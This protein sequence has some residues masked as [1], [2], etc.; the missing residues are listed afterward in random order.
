MSGTEAAEGAPATRRTSSRLT[1]R[2]AWVRNLTRPVRVF[3]ATEVGS[4]VILLA[5]ALA[6]LLWA[7]SPWGDSYEG[8]WS[9]ELSIHLGGTVLEHDLRG[10]VNDGLM[11]FFFFV[12]GLEIRRELDMGDLRERRRVA[13]PV[14]A[15]VGGMAIPALIYASFNA[16]TDA[17][18]G[19]GI[20]MATDTAFALGVLALVGRRWPL[21]LR[22]FVLTLVVVDDV[23]ALTVIALAYTDDLAFTPLL[24]AVG[25]FAVVVALRAAGVRHGAPYFLLGVALWLAL[26]QAGVHPTIAGVSMGLLATAYPPTRSDLQRAASLWRTFREQPTSQYARSASRGV[27]LAISPNERMQQIY[28]PWTS[29]LIVPLFALANAGVALDGELLERA[30][31]S[32]ITLGIVAGLVVGKL[33]GIS[34]AS[35]LA[36]RRWL[37]GFPITIAWPPLI[38]AAIVA[39]IGFT[40]SLFIAELSFEGERLA[41]AKVG[42]LAASAIA[43]GLGWAAFRLMDR[44]PARLR[45]GGR[46]QPAEPLVDLT[47]PVDPERDHIRGPADAPVTLVEYADFECPYCGQAEPVIRELLAEF[48]RDLRYVFR[49]L[50]LEDVH[51]H[52][53]LAAEAAEAAGAQGKF[54][55]MHDLLFQHQDALNK[56]DLIQYAEQLGLDME[57]FEAKLRKRKFA[58][59]VAHD[60]ES[61]DLSGVTGTPTFFANGRRHHGAFNLA[62]LTAL[63]RSALSHADGSSS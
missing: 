43:A 40:V 23:G 52:A 11:A 34:G 58:P 3:V 56:W 36:T 61:A 39:G 24:L 13:L 62:E 6:A 4:A 33:V 32:P 5:A 31:T 50:P 47:D 55:E 9:T 42:I 15:A 29:F 22:V 17:V 19:W 1:G 59:R 54:W 60:V 45:G 27:S 63:V 26:T 53:R 7:N 12:I 21:R 8:F 35:W 49:H 37:G 51:E 28:H 25:L 44:L 16:G 10:W 14:L 2:T 46:V 38:G 48:G 18:H 20:V 41:E 30:V 57:Q